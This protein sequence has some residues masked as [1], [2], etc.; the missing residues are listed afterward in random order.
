M[1]TFIIGL[2]ILIVGGSLYG[3]FCEKIVKPTDNPT[4]AVT[5]RDDVDFVPMSGKRNALIELLNIAGTGPILGPIQGALF[6]PIAFITIPIGCVI[7]GAFH[8]YMVGMIS[9]RNEGA[10]VPGLIRKIIGEHFYRIYLVFVCLLLLLIGV[11]FIYTPG[12]IFVNS[13]LNQKTSLSNPVMWIVY[14]AIFGYYIIATL[15][16]IDKIIGKIYPIFGAILIISAIAI[17]IGLFVKG[18]PLIELWNSSSY[19]WNTNFIPIF[20][21]TVTCG[22]CSGFHSTQATIISRTV[23]NEHTGRWT[24]YNMMLVEGFIAMVWAAVSMST[25]IQGMTNSHTI[26]NSPTSIVGMVAKDMLGPI[27]G[28]IAIIGVIVLPITS[29]DTALRS[30]RLMIC[31]ALGI[32]QKAKKRILLVA[33]LIFA[34]VAIILILAKANPSGFNVLWR[35]YSWAN[36]ASIIFVFAMIAIYMK[37]NNLPY[38]MALGPGCFYV[39]IVTSFILNARIGL[40]LPWPFSYIAASAS[41]IAYAVTICRIK[42]NQLNSGFAQS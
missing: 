32:S 40:S 16:P 41:T 13:L 25:Y 6:G 36:E 3:R 7:A 14:I 12:D 19:H 28:T 17:F 29:G 26:S 2:I 39:F 18:Y 5:K 4:P 1:I 23:S 30:L 11:V 34:T 21:V 35:Y 37:R 10:Q 15:L 33:L 8:D 9:I 22:I 38:I 24:F 31:D 20:F 42:S 27:G